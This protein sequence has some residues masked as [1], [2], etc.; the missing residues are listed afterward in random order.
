MVSRS[1]WE[2]RIDGDDSNGGGCKY[3]NVGGT[4]YSYQSN[5]ILD[6]DDATT[7]ASGVT[8]LTSTTGGFT[9]AMSGNMLHLYN[10]SYLDENWYEIVSYTDGNTIGLDR[11]PG[12]DG[13]G[14]GV[15]GATC[16]VGGAL[17][18]IGGL[19]AVMASL[20]TVGEVPDLNKVW[21][22][23]SATPYTLANNDYN[24]PSGSLRIEDS[25]D[26]RT[27]IIGYETVRG[28]TPTNLVQINTNGFTT[29]SPSDASHSGVFDMAETI[30]YLVSSC[31]NIK[32]YDHLG[33]GD[34]GFNMNMIFNCE[35]D[36]F[37][38]GFYGGSAVKCVARNA[39]NDGFYGVV[40][41]KCVSRD[42]GRYGFDAS[43]GIYSVAYNNNSFGMNDTSWFGSVFSAAID[44]GNTGFRNTSADF[45]MPTDCASTHNTGGGYSATGSMVNCL[46][47]NNTQGSGYPY[48]TDG[49][50]YIKIH[51]YS[52]PVQ[53]DPWEDRAQG[54]FWFN[55]GAN[56]GAVIETL[57]STSLPLDGVTDYSHIGPAQKNITVPT[58]Q[59]LSIS[60][61]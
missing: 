7:S 34:I 30:V 38:V 14:N 54:K 37:D 23:Y 17:Q 11:S 21:I 16:K 48:F 53:G 42:N 24:V 2:I 60:T 15:S 55:N 29:T 22:K 13:T 58:T 51:S 9:A 47:F 35:S 19:G 49:A 56:S 28:D 36:G 45:Y 33:S 31:K 27:G 5:P 59:Y 52:A 57:N 39:V 46:I 6:V 10:G 26:W 18:S 3:K 12:N 1:N 41:Y 40:C 25:W 44:N 61:G 8:T 32:L 20:D 4:D 50:G 43:Y